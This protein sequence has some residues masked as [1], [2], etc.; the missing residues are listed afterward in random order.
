MAEKKVF[1][2]CLMDYSLSSGE[3][4]SNSKNYEETK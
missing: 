3:M 1:K 2:A 4:I